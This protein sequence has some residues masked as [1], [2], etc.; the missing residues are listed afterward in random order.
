LAGDECSDTVIRDALEAVGL[1]AGLHLLPTRILSQGQKRRVAL[2]RLW[3]SRR[4]LWVLDEPYTS[5]DATAA[6]LVTQRME[7][8]LDEGGLVVVATHQDMTLGSGSLQHL[9][10][11]G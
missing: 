4:P 3:L 6:H 5:L 7:A 1:G 9:R 10:L 11:S 8:H 2:A